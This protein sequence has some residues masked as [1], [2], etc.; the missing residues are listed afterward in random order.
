MASI[1]KRGKDYTVIYDR[2]PD[3]KGKRKQ[4]WE[5]GY[6]YQEALKRKAEIEYA[7]SKSRNNMRINGK[8]MTVRTFYELWLSIHRVNWQYAT[9]NM[10]TQVMNDYVLPVLGGLKLQNVSPLDIEK[11]LCDVHMKPSKKNP[12][13]CLSGT[14]VLHAY[15]FTRLMFNKAVA[16]GYLDETPVTCKPPKRSHYIPTVWSADMV[17]TSLSGITDHP[18]LH[19][20][21][22]LAF[23]CSLR[24]GELLAITVA[25]IDFDDG[26]ILIEKTLQRMKLDTIQHLPN[27]SLQTVYDPIVQS[28][29]S[30]LI[31][32]DTKTFC[33]HRKVYLTQPLI[34]ELKEQ[35]LR[36]QKAA[37]YHN[38]PHNGLLFCLPE[39]GAPVEPKLC[40][41]WFSKWQECNSAYNRITF[42]Q[43]RHASATYKLIVG[44]GDIKSVQG[45]NGHASAKITLDLYAHIC[46]EN[47]RLLTMRLAHDFYND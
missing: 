43:L 42:H 46:E 25:D 9:Y 26:S 22:H 3:E 14:T 5:G 7:K 19:L 32:K 17:K 12:T 47:R 44:Q 1:L 29:Q 18:M 16:W 45:D 35:I 33:A 23:V 39:T 40:Q 31:T 10:A 20:A 4:I 27:D 15:S 41:K 28:S 36:I 6:T 13:E 38:W 30:R 11:M 34:V 21:V 8:G 2:R 37:D 24:I